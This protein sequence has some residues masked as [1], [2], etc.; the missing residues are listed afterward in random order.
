MTLKKTIASHSVT[1]LN[2]KKFLKGSMFLCDKRIWH[3][4]EEMFADNT[5]MRRIIADDGTEE[6]LT[7]TTLIKDLESK[8]LEFLETNKTNETIKTAEIDNNAEEDKK[9][10]ST[11][12]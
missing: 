12:E 7:L 10:E 9:E 1:P 11:E 2:S 4:T 5:E 8:S 6:I 3:V